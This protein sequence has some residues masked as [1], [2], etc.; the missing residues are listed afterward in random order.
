LE[1]TTGQ[2]IGIT[3]AICVILAVSGV[4]IRS[5]QRRKL[6]RLRQK[7]EA[8]GSPIERLAP[9]HPGVVAMV[10]EQYSSS[11]YVR[12]RVYSALVNDGGVSVKQ[13]WMIENG[14]VVRIS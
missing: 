8:Q 11:K 10:N 5:Q 12:R 7:I 2:L 9:A 6:D 3:V 1:A 13:I 4:A 14:R